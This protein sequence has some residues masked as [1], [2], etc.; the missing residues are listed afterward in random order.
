MTLAELILEKLAD[1]RPASRETLTVNA[2][3]AG[4]TVALSADGSDR[5]GCLVWEL[6]LQRASP[7]ALETLQTRAERCAA[8]ISGLLE[9]LKIVE[10][11]VPGSR[12]MLRS[13]TPARRGDELFYYELLLE[14]NGA[15]QLRRYHVSARSK[16]RRE[17]VAFALT[18][19]ALAKLVTDL[20]ATD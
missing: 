12:A 6:A 10:V 8:R 1:W 17:Q 15:A 3:G 20:T 13:Q 18:H 19:E 11:D 9:P 16:A 4:W 2:D 7:P 14:A 5:L